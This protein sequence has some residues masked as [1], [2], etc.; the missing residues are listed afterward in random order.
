MLEKLLISKIFQEFADIKVF[1][2][3]MQ[4]SMSISCRAEN[5]YA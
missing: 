5:R 3:F 1:H 4:Y 2:G